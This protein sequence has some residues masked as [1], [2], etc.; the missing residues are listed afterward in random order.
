MYICMFIY[1]Y[2]GVYIQTPPLTYTCVSVCVCVCLNSQSTVIV[3]KVVACVLVHVCPARHVPFIC[4]SVLQ[5]VAVCCS[6]LQCVA[7]CCS[8]VR[9]WLSYCTCFVRFDSFMRCSVFQC[10]AVCGV[11]LQYVAVLEGCGFVLVHVCSVRHDSFMYCSVLQCVAVFCSMLQNETGGG[12]CV[13]PCLP[14]ESGIVDIYNMYIQHIYI[15]Y[16]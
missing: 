2:T 6:V 12:C 15:T 9:W 16:M 1:F 8:I 11:A 10:V 4:C 3:Q 14:C 5:C 13:C 7:V